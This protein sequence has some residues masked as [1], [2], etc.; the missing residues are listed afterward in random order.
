V[1]RGCAAYGAAALACLVLLTGALRLWRADLRVPLHYHWGGDAVLYQALVKG[2]LDNGWFLHN[3]FLGM[4]T[5]L[6][7]HDFPFGDALHFLAI[8]LLGQAVPDSA[9]VLNLFFLH[10][11]VLATW[12]ALFVLRRL[13][14]GYPVAV[15][16]ALLFAFLPYHFR[17]ATIHPFLSAYYLVPLTALL[18]LR[19]YAGEKA[20]PRRA[21]GSLGRAVVCVLTGAAGVYYAYFSCFF[22]LA[23][24]LAAA[25]AAR[26]R[27]PLWAAAK[28]TLLVCLSA[29]AALAPTPL[30]RWRHGPNPE[31]V[32][33]DKAQAEIFGLKVA[34][35]LLPVTGHRVGWLA[36]LKATYNIPSRPLVNENDSAALGLVG[37]FGFLWLTARFFLRRR[38]AAP[39][40]VADGLAFCNTAAVLLA[41]IGGAGSLLSLFGLSWIRGYNRISV[42]IGFFALTAVALLL[43][44]AADRFARTG[45]SRAVFLGLL[46]V[47]LSLGCL[48]QT[49]ARDIPLYAQ[50]RAEYLGEAEFVARVEAAVPA[51]SQIFQLP[52]NSFVENGPVHQ[53]G[54]Y[55]L[56]RPYLHS[57]GLRW[58]YGAMRGREADRWQTLLLGLPLD[59]QVQRLSFAGF[60]GIYVDRAGYLDRA[61]SLEASLADLLDAAP[62]VSGNER[63]AFYSMAGYNRALREH[64]T[65]A[66]WQQRRER[67][68]HPVMLTWGGGF[69]PTETIPEEGPFRWCGPRGELTLTNPRPVPSKLT[70]QMAFAVAGSSHTAPLAL[71]GDL[72]SC[73]LVIGPRWK[74]VERTLEVPPGSHVIRLACDGPEC[75]APGDPRQII[76]RVGRCRL[77]EAD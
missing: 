67:A 42:F 55:D 12:T 70:L 43:Q 76:F 74:E 11:F 32:E 45:R 7:L 10:T 5:G 60:G 38:S 75:Q 47:L 1:L 22:F 36:D 63:F 50:A 23:A 41:T 57:H 48:D 4:P 40:G 9:V 51:G 65:E 61:A 66:E 14:V 8:K 33:R 58:S 29:A 28:L 37:G 18:A 49:T 68:L 19:L 15:V 31:A 64:Y 54:P 34:Q 71:T 2:V 69:H 27:A 20:G 39:A 52:Y 53:L 3:D 30:Y 46:A 56:L 21:A 44:G 26:R 59:Q 16:A 77:T 35:L 25:C 17:R 13:G 62:L 72:F 6:D 24:G 73:D